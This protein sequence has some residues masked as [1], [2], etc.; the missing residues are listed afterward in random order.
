MVLQ[1]LK[2]PFWWR[3]QWSLRLTI[4]GTFWNRRLSNSAFHPS[5]YFFYHFSCVHQS[6]TQRILSRRDCLKV[7]TLIPELLRG[8]QGGMSHCVWLFGSGITTPILKHGCQ[9]YFWYRFL[10]AY[11]YLTSKDCVISLPSKTYWQDLLQIWCI[12]A[13]HAIQVAMS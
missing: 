6:A 11:V 3:N 7:C 13:F 10:L 4:F 12:L 9:F 1:W 8:D 2:A 5:N